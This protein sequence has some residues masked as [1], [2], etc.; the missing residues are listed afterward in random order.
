MHVWNFG[1]IACKTR[2][3]D[4]KITSH[5]RRKFFLMSHE[6]R[7]FFECNIF[8]ALPCFKD[9]MA[10]MEHP[11]FSLSTRP[12]RRVLHYEHNGNTVTIIPSGNGLATIHDKDILLYCASYLRA[13]INDGKMPSRTVRFTAHDFF[14]STHRLTDGRT[15]Q[16]F[17]ESLNRLRGTTINTN[18]KISDIHIEEGFGLIDTWRAIKEDQSGRVIAAEIKVSEWFYNSVISNE[19]LTINRDYFKLRMPIERRIYELVRKHCG[20]GRCFRISLDK[21]Q[22]KVGSK[23]TLREFRRMIS[24]IATQNHL[25]DYE[26]SQ[27][28]DMV[29]FNNRHWKTLEEITQLSPPSLQP[30]TFE[31]AQKVAP[32]LDVADLEQQWRSWLAKK[33]APQRPDAAFIAFCRKKFQQLGGP[34]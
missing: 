5:Y 3:I 23:S 7:D 28:D 17:R 31:K 13:A 25:P 18:I 21:L 14:V 8:A 10:S 2:T 30:V 16:R 33:K 6:A 15:Y 12:D 11:V 1:P 29:S 19:L 4:Q 24:K 32:G 22:K 20:E 26:I 27:A 34:Q 9:D